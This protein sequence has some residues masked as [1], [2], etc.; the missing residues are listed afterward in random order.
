M[1]LKDVIAP[2][3][4]GVSGG[5]DSLGCALLMS[6]I[7][8]DI[9]ALT[10]DHALRENSHEEA[11]WVGKILA[12]HQIAHHILKWKHSGIKTGIQEKAREARYQLM[13]AWCVQ[14]NIKTL[15]TAHHAMDQW[16]TFMM[17]L[18]RGSGLR[19]LCGIFEKKKMSFGFLV[20]PFLKDHPDLFKTFL[21]ERNIEWIEDPS[22]QR[23]DF[24]RI[25]LRKKYDLFNDMGLSCQS[26]AKSTSI[27]CEV[28]AYVN[29]QI[30]FN[31]DLVFCD[32]YLDIEKFKK[33][34]LYLAKCVL[35]CI[36]Q[37]VCQKQYKASW[38]LIARMVDN[39]ENTQTGGGC[40]LRKCKKGIFIQKDPRIKSN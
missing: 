21:L 13:E 1:N 10:V 8:P 32:S 16:E 15:V 9:V 23:E 26:I 11:L 33:L 25:A 39:I 17:R 29:D 12:Q 31:I 27:L 5:A 30:Q 20:R 19:G 6:K 37:K 38:D 24:E 34:P 3:A 7:Y 2:V 14:N 22:N 4:I 36:L 35:Q 28:D 18:K 40:V